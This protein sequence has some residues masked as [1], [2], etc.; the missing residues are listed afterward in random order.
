[1]EFFDMLFSKSIFFYIFF[2]G[3]PVTF[4]KRL[5]YTRLT[6]VF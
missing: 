4:C 6:Y 5:F 2:V 1:M 3:M